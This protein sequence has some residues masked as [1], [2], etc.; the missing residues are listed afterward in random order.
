MPVSTAANPTCGSC[1][2]SHPAET[3]S[4]SVLEPTIECR[5]L[6]RHIMWFPWWAKCPLLWA[7]SSAVNCDCYDEG[8][9]DAGER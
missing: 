4:P 2:W 5:Y 1:R 7:G 6:I 8:D 9:K 3:T